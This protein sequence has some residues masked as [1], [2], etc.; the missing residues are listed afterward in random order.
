MVRIF[1]SQQGNTLTAVRTRQSSDARWRIALVSN[2]IFVELRMILRYV[3]RSPTRVSDD[4]G[5]FYF[6]KKLRKIAI[7]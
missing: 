4:G 2:F 6:K 5:A 7:R 1:L 3:G